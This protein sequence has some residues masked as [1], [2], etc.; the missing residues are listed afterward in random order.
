MAEGSTGEKTEEATPHKRRE[1]RKEGNVMQSKDV[2]TAAFI[3]LAFFILRIMARFMYSVTMGSMT[4]WFTLAGGGMDGN[5][6]RIDEMPAAPKLI[7]EIGKAVLFTAGPILLASLLIPIIATGI[8]TKF[9]FSKKSFQFKLSKLNPFE[10]IKKM[11]S[12]S[13]LFELAKSLIKMIILMAVVYSEIQSRL[14]DFARLMRMELISALLY[15]ADA[16]FSICMKIAMVF[17]AVAAVDFLFQKYKWE[18]DMKMTKQEVKEE[19]KQM[20]GDPQIK[21]KRRQKQQQMAM[22]RMMQDVPSA[23]VVIRNPTHFAVAVRYDESSD[24][25]PVV[26]AK[27]ADNVAFRII[28]KAEEN[29]VSVVENVPLARALFKEVEIGREIPYDFYRPLAEVLSFVY[30]MKGRMPKD[31]EKPPVNY[32]NY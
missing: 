8:Q 6:T 5:G 1:Q 4:Y 24:R 16:V 3:L 7:L 28:E 30:G 13:A 21:S 27:G 11:F 2:V 18:K 14:V 9:I 26:V 15:V 32:P 20:E 31:M 17:V 23:D 25:A 12:V 10:G 22:S 19:Y 29:N